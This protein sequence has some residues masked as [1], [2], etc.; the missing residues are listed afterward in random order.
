MSNRFVKPKHDFPILKS[1][2]MPVAFFVLCIVLFNWGIE[3]LSYST[4]TERL[5]STRRAVMRAAV[6]CYAI[7]GQYPPG[8]GY[9]TEHYGLVADTDRYIIDYSVFASNIM[10]SITVLPKNFADRPAAMAEVSE[11]VELSAGLDS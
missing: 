10:P 8:I 7:E 9:L 1:I 5:E 4:Q 3:S 6:Q 2:L 11:L